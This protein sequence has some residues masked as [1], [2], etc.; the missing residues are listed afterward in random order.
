MTPES[1]GTPSTR[2]TLTAK[3]GEPLNDEQTR[4]MV[5]ATA[6]AIA[7]RTGI[8]VSEIETT[9]DSVSVTIAGDRLAA[10]GFAAEL[11][12]LTTRWYLGKFGVSHLWGPTEQGHDHHEPQD[13]ESGN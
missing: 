9:G 13:D 5:V 8:P 3:I 4:R 1:S 2:V 6:E 12:T 10:I 7:E 11:R